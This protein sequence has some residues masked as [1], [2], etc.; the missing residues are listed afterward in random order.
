VLEVFTEPYECRVD[1][2]RIAQIV[3]NLVENAYKYT[4]EKTRVTVTA[5]TDGSGGLTLTIADEGPGIPTE[6]RDVLFDAFT[7]IEETA[8]GREGVGLGLYLVSQLVAAMDGEIDLASSSKGTAFKI[9]I[10]C[11]SRPL[12][13]AKLGLVRE[14]ESRA[15]SN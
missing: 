1:A 14:N 11:K 10:P 15:S 9:R 6:K 8:A 2:S 7:R 12:H 5:K 13:K 3:R 4:P